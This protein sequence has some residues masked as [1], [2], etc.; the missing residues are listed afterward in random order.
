[1]MRA[2]CMN[3]K[4]TREVLP[5]EII[6]DTCLGLANYGEFGRPESDMEPTKGR[7]DYVTV[8]KY[9]GIE[10]K[11]LAHHF[12]PISALEAQ[13]VFSSM[14]SGVY[15]TVNHSAPREFTAFSAYLDFL[16]RVDQKG[17]K[18]KTVSEIIA[19]K[20]LPEKRIADTLLAVDKRKEVINKPRVETDKLLRPGQKFLEAIEA[21]KAGKSSNEGEVGR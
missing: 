4:D 3:D 15:G 10:R 21:M 13:Q 5:D 7:N 6:Y 17:I 12:M 2:G 1:E 20:L 8:G 19:E 16:H 11:W 18:S 9:N 14:R